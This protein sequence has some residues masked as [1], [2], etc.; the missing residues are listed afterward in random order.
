MLCVPYQ[1]NIKTVLLLD[2][3]VYCISST[4]GGYCGLVKVMLT[5]RHCFTIV[6]SLLYTLCI[7]PPY[8]EVYVGR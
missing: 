1:D 6:Y 7:H 5:F 2:V 3:F 8:G 4:P